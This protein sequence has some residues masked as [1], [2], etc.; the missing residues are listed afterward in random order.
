LG[1]ALEGRDAT[2][3]G[4]EG[5]KRREGYSEGKVATLQWVPSLKGAI[6]ETSYADQ[7]K[8][9]GNQANCVTIELS[10][11]V[12]FVH[13]ILPHDECPTNEQPEDQ[14][15]DC[16]QSGEEDRKEAPTRPKARVDLE[17]SVGHGIGKAKGVEA[18]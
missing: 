7:C 1:L 13:S 10:N 3:A 11:A 4:L 5:L 18:G 16:W 2:T 14:K 17:I 12:G 6:Q 8:H 15:Q 9:E